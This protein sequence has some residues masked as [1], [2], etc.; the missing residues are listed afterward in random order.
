MLPRGFSPW[1]RAATG[2]TAPAG[3]RTLPHRASNSEARNPK[4]IHSKKPQGSKRVDSAPFR[5]F[6]V[7]FFVLVSYFALRISSLPTGI[8]CHWRL[9]SAGGGLT[10]RRQKGEGAAV[11]PLRGGLSR[12]RRSI[13]PSSEKVECPLFPFESGPLPGRAQ[14]RNA[15]LN[16]WRVSALTYRWSQGILEFGSPPASTPGR[17]PPASVHRPISRYAKEHF[18]H[19]IDH[20][21]P[22]ICSPRI[23]AAITSRNS[24]NSYTHT[25]HSGDLSVTRCQ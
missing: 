6:R 11:S 5:S 3:R 2:P 23:T 10:P 7:R 18:A 14:H 21:P 22:R 15:A 1:L 19:A 20:S 8:R 4:Q 25:G 17:I 16:S 12:L 9:A 24:R 13:R